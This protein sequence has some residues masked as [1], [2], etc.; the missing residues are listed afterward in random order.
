VHKFPPVKEQMDEIRRGA[1][2]II[3]EEELALKL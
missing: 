2:E 3:P 1:V